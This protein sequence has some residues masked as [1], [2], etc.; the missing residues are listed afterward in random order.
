MTIEEMKKA[1][2]ELGYGYEKLAEVCGLSTEGIRRIFLGRTK[3]PR[4]STLAALESVLGCVL[5]DA[6]GGCNTDDGHDKNT[7]CDTDNEYDVGGQIVHESASV[8]GKVPDEKQGKCTVED[9]FNLPKELRCELIDGVLYNMAEP[10]LAH[11]I[12]ACEVYSQI[13]TQIEKRNGACLPV[14]APVS[15]RLFE[16][17]ETVIVPD[18]LI[19]CDRNKVKRWGILGAPDFVM[20]VLSPSTGKRDAT[21]KLEKYR[22]AGVQEYWMLDLRKKVMIVY[23]MAKEATPGVH[24]LSGTLGLHIYNEEVA[25]NL[26]ALSEIIDEYDRPMLSES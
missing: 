23:R 26:D 21:L 15:V 25:V 14:L 20:E 3:R 8:Y 18:F 16:E 4:A 11:Q 19:A 24:P 22:Q 7:E 1:K 10:S 2:E 13:R 9:Y 17:E 6:D 5:D 12:T